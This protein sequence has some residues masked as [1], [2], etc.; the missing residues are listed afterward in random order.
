MAEPK[1]PTWNVSSKLRSNARALRRNSTDAERLLWAALR[2]HRLNGAGFRRQ[3]PIEN[4]V[5]DFV[6]HAAKLV[7]ELDGGSIFP[8]KLSER[9]PRDQ[10]S[11]RRKAL[12]FFVSAITTS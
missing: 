8:T 1:H 9:T 6:C 10:P 4:Y 12:R 11:S 7:I 2:D 5:A 3:V